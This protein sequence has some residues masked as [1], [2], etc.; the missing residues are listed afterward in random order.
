MLIALNGRLGS[1]KDTVFER[2]MMLHEQLGV[3]RPQQITFAAK[4]KQAL[5][6]LLD[7]AVEDIESR[8]RLDEIG[9]AW[10]LEGAEDVEYEPEY[11]VRTLLQRMGT[12][13]GRNIFGQNFWVDQALPQRF[14]HAQGFYVVTDC[15]FDNE[16]ERVIAL[17]GHVVRIDGPR[18]DTGDHPSEQPLNTEPAGIIS[19]LVFDDGYRALDAAIMA[20]L[21]PIVENEAEEF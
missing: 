8:K 12:E 18:N 7:L 17:G 9:L 6:A 5:A 20:A 4:L 1:G 3:V 21:V 11:T 19:N 2:L 16:A 10:V 15:R 13:V 14:D